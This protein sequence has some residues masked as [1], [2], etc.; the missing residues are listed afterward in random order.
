M[1]RRHDPDGGLL[2][3]TKSRVRRY[4][5]VAFNV[6][7]LDIGVDIPTLAHLVPT[8]FLTTPILVAGLL[9][10]LATLATR[11]TVDVLEAT[12]SEPLPIATPARPNMVELPSE[13]HAVATP[14]DDHPPPSAVPDKST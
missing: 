13:A 8:T 9:L 7:N 6:L 2:S 11:V 12:Q 4:V 14:T 5:I 3:W 1:S 10:A